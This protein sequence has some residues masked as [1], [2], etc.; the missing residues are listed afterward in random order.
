VWAQIIDLLE[1]NHFT[2][3]VRY[4]A[5]DASAAFGPALKEAVGN[6]K[7][8]IGVCCSPPFPDLPSRNEES[9]HATESELWGSMVCFSC[10]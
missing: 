3:M 6:P 1:R 5:T 7:L 2:D 9:L 10:T 4:V 8:D